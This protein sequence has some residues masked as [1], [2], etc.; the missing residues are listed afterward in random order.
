MRN[1]KQIWDRRDKM[2]TFSLL[3][4]F[5]FPAKNEFSSKCKGKDLKQEKKIIYNERLSSEGFLT[6]ITVCIDKT[7][8][9]SLSK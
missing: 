9:C 2:V 5:G 3:A 6:V 7:G 4:S 8:L 1:T